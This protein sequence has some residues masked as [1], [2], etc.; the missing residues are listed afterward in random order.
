MEYWK[1]SFLI[2]QR[3][4]DKDEFIFIAED[5]KKSIIEKIINSCVDK[6]YL[7][8]KLLIYGDIDEEIL[9][10]FLFYTSINK[11]KLYELF[12]ESPNRY[13]STFMFPLEI[14]QLPKIRNILSENEFAELKTNLNS[15]FLVREIKSSTSVIL[16]QLFKTCFYFTKI[17][18]YSIKEE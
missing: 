10:N 17:N 1:F 5:L 9:I 2:L 3:L 11:K 13:G 12:V 16:K 8:A 6:N 15:K 14:S 4:V 7:I 18:P